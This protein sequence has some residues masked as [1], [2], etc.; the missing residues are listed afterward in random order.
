MIDALIYAEKKNWNENTTLKD[1]C[2][3]SRLLILNNP[4]FNKTS[5]NNDIIVIRSCKFHTHL[6][7]PLLGKPT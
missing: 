5:Y 6:I 1:A 3:S 4:N 7:M 2:L